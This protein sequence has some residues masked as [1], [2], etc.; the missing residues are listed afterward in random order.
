MMRRTPIRAALLAAMLAA[1]L[2]GGAAAAGIDTTATATLPGLCGIDPAVSSL[3]G[4]P[5][6]PQPAGSSSTTTTTTTTTPPTT[7]APP[8]PAAP[9]RP[10]PPT[11]APAAPA[12][13]GAAAPPS[14]RAGPGLVAAATVRPQRCRRPLPRERPVGRAGE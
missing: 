9:A 2:C 1:T 11:T 10:A 4:C 14:A 13:N 8:G 3:L 12:A 5:E 6:A 7:T